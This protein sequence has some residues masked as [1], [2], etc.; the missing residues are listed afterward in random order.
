MNE[1]KHK[2]VFMETARVKACTYP[3]VSGWKRIDRFYCE[4]C[5]EIKELTK[6][7]PHYHDKPEWFD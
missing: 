5:L 1:C 6:E 2:W 3:P 4:K 7:T